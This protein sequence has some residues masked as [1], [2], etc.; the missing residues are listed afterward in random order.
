LILSAS[1]PVTPSLT[2]A[3]DEVLGFLE[4]KRGDVPNHF[5]DIDLPIADSEEDDRELTARCQSGDRRSTRSKSGAV[6]TWQTAT[7]ETEICRQRL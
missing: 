4:V 5:N 1:S 2:I 6:G 7:L 3:F